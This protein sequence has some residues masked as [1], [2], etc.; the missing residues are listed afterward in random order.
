MSKFC[1]KCG[2]ELDDSAVFCSGCG[3]SQQL[4]TTSTT[5]D[6]VNTNTN[7]DT[8]ATTKQQPTQTTSNEQTTYTTNTQS[9]TNGYTRSLVKN[10]SIALSIILS[11]ITCGIYGLFWYAFMVDDA[12]KVSGEYDSTSGGLTILYSLLTCGLYKIYWSYKVGKQLYNAGSNCGKDIS[13]NSILYL[14]LSLFGLS[15][16][17][18]ALI[19]NDLNSFSN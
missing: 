1:F 3:A 5:D 12:N 9:N 10:R 4:N 16:I 8:T 19:Q 14:I 18:D 17:S 6:N 15:I 13:D 7:N 11:I 2:K